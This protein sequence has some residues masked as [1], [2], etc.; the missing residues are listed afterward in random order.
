VWVNLFQNA[1][2]A[3]PKGGELRAA[4][5]SGRR[6]GWRS[7]TRATA[8]I[9]RGREDLAAL[10][11]DEDPGHGPGAPFVKKIVDAH[12]GRIWCE[13]EPSKGTTFFVEIPQ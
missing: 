6:C 9:R 7:G 5:A 4:S 8:S 12:A 10:L 3:M 13:S 2:E 1:I 11:H